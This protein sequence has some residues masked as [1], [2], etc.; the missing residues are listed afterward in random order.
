MPA[1]PGI[2]SSCRTGG[3]FQMSN[4]RNSTNAAI[5]LFQLS[6]GGAGERDPLADNLVDHDDLGVF[7]AG[8]FR[9][10]SRGPDGRRDQQR[11]PNNAR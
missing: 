5:Q 10:P 6:V 7:A 11:T 3:G 2:F 9:H 8:V 1:P 4:N